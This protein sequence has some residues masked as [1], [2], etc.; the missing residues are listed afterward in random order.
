MKI[1]DYLFSQKTQVKDQIEKNNKIIKEY[2]SP[3]IHLSSRKNKD[4]SLSS[5]KTNKSYNL[6]YSSKHKKEKAFLTEQIKDEN[7]YFVQLYEKT[8]KI[9]PTKVEET[10]K[11]LILQYRNNDYKIPDL[12]DKKNLFSQNPLLLVGRDLDQ[13]Y[14]YNEKNIN[15]ISKKHKMNKKHVNFIKKEMIYMEKF[16]KRNNDFKD[17]SKNSSNTNEYNGPESLNFKNDKSSLLF[18][19]SVWDKI[20]RQK[21][22]QK[23][24]LLYKKH[25][26]ERQKSLCYTPKNFYSNTEKEN[27]IGNGNDNKNID[28]YCTLHNFKSMEI[29]NKN[30]NSINN[31]NSISKLPSIDNIQSIYINTSSP[32]KKL[33]HNLLSLKTKNQIQNSKLIHEIEEIKKTI[34]NKDIVG[35]DNYKSLKS[36]ENTINSNRTNNKSLN[37]TLILSKKFPFYIDNDSNKNKNNDLDKSIYIKDDNKNNNTIN[38]N[39]DYNHKKKET[40]SQ[41]LGKRKSCLFDGNKLSKLRI[42]NLIQ[43]KSLPFLTLN[44]L[45][46]EKDPHKFLNILK[47]INLKQFNIKEIEKIMR[48]YCQTVLGYDKKIIDRIVSTN[49]NEENLYLIIENIIQKTKKNSPEFYGKNDIRRDLEQVNKSIFNLKKNYIFG[50]TYTIFESNV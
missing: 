7:K 44:K 10:F 23:K 2:L 30:S 48:S 39:N 13:Y 11:D 43:K 33:K 46:N 45:L 24:L 19:D 50:K 26:K 28:S 9:Y 18:V 1:A 14:M 36:F 38:I 32:I 25:Q 3:K 4:K 6:Y 8:K 17:K 41:I 37:K 40:D 42:F 21:I 16:L 31:T 15:K 49:K 34:N 27:E 5:F 47:R 29:G 22:K 12:S 20:K 35:L